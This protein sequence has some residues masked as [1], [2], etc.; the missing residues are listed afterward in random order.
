M[1]EYFLILYAS[2]VKGFSIF[3]RYSQFCFPINKIREQLI[4]IFYTLE[5]KLFAPKI[6]VYN[7]HISNNELSS[8]GIHLISIVM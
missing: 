4:T 5:I 2:N 7:F 1:C 8:S 3:A 6:I